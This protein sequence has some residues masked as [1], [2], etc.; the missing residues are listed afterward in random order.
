MSLR[1][2]VHENAYQMALTPVIGRSEVDTMQ[3][4]F[5]TRNLVTGNP[6]TGAND[7]KPHDELGN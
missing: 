2:T 5:S 3:L 1:Y 7:G 4:I 6:M